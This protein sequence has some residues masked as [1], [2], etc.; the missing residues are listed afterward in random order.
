MIAG[1]SGLLVEELYDSEED[2]LEKAIKNLQELTWFGILEHLNESLFLFD[3]VASQIGLEIEI[4][5]NFN[6]TEKTVESSNI[7]ALTNSKIASVNKLDLKLYSYALKLFRKRI[8]V[9]KQGLNST[10]KTYTFSSFCNNETI[11]TAQCISGICDLELE[12]NE[13]KNNS[14]Q[15]LVEFGEVP[16]LD[17]ISKRPQC[18]TLRKKRVGSYRWYNEVFGCVFGFDWLRKTIY[19]LQQENLYFSTRSYFPFKNLIDGHYIVVFGAAQSMGIQVRLK[20][21]YLL[22][23]IIIVLVLVLVLSFY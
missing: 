17:Y 10:I 19:R 11:E 8:S 22:I 23:S 7:D 1:V 12:V 5:R 6:N 14:F 15:G 3:S 2:M 13:S 18:E 21:I 16:D 20:I 4:S 9:V